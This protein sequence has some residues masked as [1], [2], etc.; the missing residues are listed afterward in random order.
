MIIGSANIND[1]SMLGDRDSEIALFVEDTNLV[2]CKMNGHDWQA[3]E[4]IRNIRIALWRQHLGDPNAQVDDPICDQTY[5]IVWMDR[6]QLN[7]HMY[8]VGLD[9][10]AS[11]YNC[12]TKNDFI[13]AMR[14]QAW[15]DADEDA[16]MTVL[17]E[18]GRAACRAGVGRYG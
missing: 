2:P 9:K 13:A 14:K 8:E 6:A 7:T 17:Q 11:V 16:V 4:T 5:R 12:R 15:P 10:E 18:I 1:R 3:G